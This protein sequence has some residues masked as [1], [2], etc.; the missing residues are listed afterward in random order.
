ME[1]SKYYSLEAVNDFIEKH[2]EEIVDIIEGVL[3]DDYILNIG[4]RY[5][6]IRAQ[7]VNHWQGVYVVH[8][9]NTLEKCYK[10]LGIEERSEQL[11]M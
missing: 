4:S 6:L 5:I 1:C 2:G 3:L 10:K 11:A 7:F 9:Y 8:N